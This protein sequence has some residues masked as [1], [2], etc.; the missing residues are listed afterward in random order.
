MTS[1]TFG[2]LEADPAEVGLDPARLARIDSHFRRYVDEAASPAR[3]SPS[4]ATTG[5]H[6]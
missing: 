4:P 2:T 6:T 5:S 1:P 3:R